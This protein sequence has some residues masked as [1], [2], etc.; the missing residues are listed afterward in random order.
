MRRIPLS[1]LVYIGLSLVWLAVVIGGLLLVAT[2]KAC[3]F[4]PAGFDF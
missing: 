2:S 1:R 4:E 3:Q